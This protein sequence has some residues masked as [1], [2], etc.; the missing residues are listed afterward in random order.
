MTLDENVAR[1]ERNRSW[2]NNPDIPAWVDPETVGLDQFF[3]RADIAARC[4]ASLLRWM[5][6]DGA[7]AGDYK[8]LEPGVALAHFTTFCRRSAVSVSTSCR[9]APMSRGRTFSVG[10]HLKTAAASPSSAILRSAIAHGSR[11]LSSTTRRDSPI[12]WV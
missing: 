9:C 4:Y 3:T 1:F 12:T 6:R 5:E 8:F 2:R 10:A 7:R 11:S